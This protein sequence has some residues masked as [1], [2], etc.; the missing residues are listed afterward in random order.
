MKTG[1]QREEENGK[2]QGEQIVSQNWISEPTKIHSLLDPVK[3]AYGYQWWVSW[4]K[5]GD[6]KIKAIF[7]S[8]SGSKFI[9]IIQEMDL[10]AVFTG[11]NFKMKNHYAPIKMLE[12]YILKAIV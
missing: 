1:F 11:G 12:K 2:W 9:Y 10:V 7:A 5:I 4:H 6:K 3:A 8:G